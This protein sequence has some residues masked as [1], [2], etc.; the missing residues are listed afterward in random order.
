MM[1]KMRKLLV[2]LTCLAM[3]LALAACGSTGGS[4]SNPSGNSG[5]GSSGGSAGDGTVYKVGI[6]NWMDHASLNQIVESPGW[7][8]RAPSWGSPSITRTIMATPR[9]TRASSARSAPTWWPTAW[10]SW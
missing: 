6:V 9:A 1:K 8:P 2:L 3:V 10:T 5:S 7:T 4:A